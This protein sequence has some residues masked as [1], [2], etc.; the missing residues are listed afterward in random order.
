MP[1]HRQQSLQCPVND[2]AAA[3][4]EAT[5]AE[6]QERLLGGE[7]DLVNSSLLNGAEGSSPAP[8][9]RKVIMLRH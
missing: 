9:S 1:L 7:P 2:L 3:L 8:S 6:E 5:S 4:E